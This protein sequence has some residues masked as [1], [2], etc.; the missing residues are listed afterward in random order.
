MQRGCVVSNETNGERVYVANLCVFDGN[1]KLLFCMFAS[2]GESRLHPPRQKIR[3]I[4]NSMFVFVPPIVFSFV[5]Y[6]N[7]RHYTFRHYA[8]RVSPRVCVKLQ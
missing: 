8:G 5:G 3:T 7:V 6:V 4:V 2:K 1:Q